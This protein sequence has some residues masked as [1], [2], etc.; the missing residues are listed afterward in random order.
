MLIV[1]KP[2]E[3]MLYN[4][5]L[6]LIDVWLDKQENLIT[7][8]EGNI[9]IDNIIKEMEVLLKEYPHE[10]ILKD[11][12]FITG[13]GWKHYH[14]F[15]LNRLTP[16]EKAALI[17][18]RTGIDRFYNPDFD[19]VAH[20]E[21]DIKDMS[22]PEEMFKYVQDKIKN[23]GTITP[24][25]VIVTQTQLNMMDETLEKMEENLKTEKE[26]MENK[27]QEDQNIEELMKNEGVKE[28][29]EN[30]KK[31]ENK[32]KESETKT[33]DEQKFKEETKAEQEEAKKE[34]TDAKE[35]TK[36][37]FDGIGWKLGLGVAVAGV[38]AAGVW[39]IKNKVIIVDNEL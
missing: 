32:E 27:N 5:Y 23:C 2:E 12:F 24:E 28:N 11:Y 19:M 38:I 4:I 8:K 36:N 34:E 9:K 6:K 35:E 15:N 26:A 37:K 21:E 10:A 1:E 3:M 7:I 22:G 18:I 30:I 17:N 20:E 33:S 31:E 25:D 39:Y 16:K 14:P 29:M 13:E